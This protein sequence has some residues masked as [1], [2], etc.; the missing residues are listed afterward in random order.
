MFIASTVSDLKKTREAVARCVTDS[1]NTPILIER[2]SASARRS[3]DIVEKAIADAE[4]FVLVIGSRLGSTIDDIKNDE[5]YIEYEYRR[6]LMYNK[7]IIVLMLSDE[8]FLKNIDNFEYDE[9]GKIEVEKLRKFR[10]RIKH[11]NHVIYFSSNTQELSIKFSRSL[12]DVT[13]QLNIIP[14]GNSTI[15]IYLE[16][17]NSVENVIEKLQSL[18]SI[19]LHFSQLVGI[20]AIDYP[21]TIQDIKTASLWVKFFGN[22]KVIS[23]FVKSIESII[24]YMRKNHTV[25]GKIEVLVKLLNLSANLKEEGV[26]TEDLNNNI[27]DSALLLAKDFNQMLSETSILSISTETETIKKLK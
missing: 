17:E 9:R 1:G 6:A 15:E 4:I 24:S 23:L 13:R 26:D 14:M 11:S 12:H 2:F 5:S 18:N 16:T 8:E 3:L 7:P 21:L 22:S 20:S 10:E 19:Y 25:E 27:N